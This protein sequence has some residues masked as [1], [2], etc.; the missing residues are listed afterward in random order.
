[1][2]WREEQTGQWE[3]RRMSLL[4]YFLFTFTAHTK[5]NV[6]AMVIAIYS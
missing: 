6:S 4:L 3:R 5:A 1:M 2:H